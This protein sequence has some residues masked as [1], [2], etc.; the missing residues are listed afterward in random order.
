[1]ASR[2]L[3]LLLIPCSLLLACSGSGDD[4]N[5]CTGVSCAAIDACHL[6]GT[7]NPATG[8]CSNPVAA[9]GLACP[10]GACAAGVCVAA[11]LCA[12]V[13][14]APL[15]PCHPAGSCDS[16]T[17][18]CVSEPAADGSACAGGL[19]SSGVCVAVGGSCID[20]V[21]NAAESDVDCGGGLCTECVD[22]KSCGGNSDCTSGWCSSGTC[23]PHVTA[24]V[25]DPGPPRSVPGGVRIVLDGTRSRSPLG[26]IA[27][28]SWTQTSGPTVHLS[29]AATARP[30]FDAP[31][32]DA[33]E[34][35]T[36]ELTVGDGSS[37]ATASLPV[38]IYPADRPG[39]TTSL[40]LILDATYEG[41]L[42]RDTAMTYLV[43]S[44][45][46]DPRLPA[47]YQGTGGPSS[48]TTALRIV[49]Q[50]FP[51]LSPEAQEVVQPFL[52]PPTVPGSYQGPEGAQP[53]A[54]G[55]TGALQ[56]TAPGWVGVSSEHAVIWYEADFANG[57]TLATQLS[58]ELE[59]KIWSELEKLF[60]PAHMPV[61]DDAKF[62]LIRGGTHGKLNIYLVTP[63]RFSNPYTLG[64]QTPYD[65]P[66]APSWIQLLRTQPFSGKDPVGLAQILAHEMMHSC[67]D[68]YKQA[69]P[70]EGHR[71]IFEGTARWA[72]DYVYPE[73]DSEHSSTSWLLDVPNK[74]LDDDWSQ[75][76][77]GTYLFFQYVTRSLDDDDF[78]RR[79]FAFFEEEDALTAV[80][81]ALPLGEES[82]PF[83]WAGFIEAAWNRNPSENYWRTDRM[84][85]GAKPQT[86]IE[87]SM[88]SPDD[89]YPFA[90]FF[91]RHLSARYFVFKFP[92]PTARQIFFYDGFTYPLKLHE[93]DGGKVI[94][95]AADWEPDLDRLQHTHTRVLSNRLDS[96]ARV[97]PPSMPGAML[98]CQD[99]PAERV[100]ELVI[101]FGYSKPE[102]GSIAPEGLDSRLR[103]S[104]IGCYAWSGTVTAH[105]SPGWDGPAEEISATVSWERDPS[106]AMMGLPYFRVALVQGTWTMSGQRGNCTYAGSM[107]FTDS[108]LGGM[109][110]FF[111]QF[112]EGP[113]HRSY[114]AGGSALQ[115]ASYTRTCVDDDGAVTVT[116]GQT[117]VTWL[118]T[119][120]EANPE[121]LPQVAADG[122][123]ASGTADNGHMVYSWSFTST[124]PP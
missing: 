117:P 108:V 63:A 114:G 38:R 124:P 56:V 96:W 122:L 61:L 87:V 71:W 102:P 54:K 89:S 20:G 50:E 100:D 22:G 40:G 39:E 29:G 82:L 106:F 6:P 97:L 48:G 49:A 62:T 35:L 123:T 12:G 101:A 33:G 9:N 112:I 70:Y 64:T 4:A 11:D 67:Q 34:S 119:S 24:L 2:N 21:K 98:L 52:L 118:S 121:W 120:R 7:C 116:S 69:Q 68:S 103:A 104:N 41:R 74:S 53:L 26:A 51:R 18:A 27:S 77:Y 28:W 13:V 78:I 85:R 99:D 8:V 37:T 5:A 42:D 47:Q 73:I 57:L 72:E 105:T 10:G 58:R 43:F 88:S 86:T 110:A 19:C 111:P 23:A 95:P 45:Y 46:G 75:R 32:A 66:P 60:T 14:C 90:S 17:G 76:P 31:A 92:D 93:V 79:V 25:A 44:V 83:V 113:A 84:D 30:E 1:M 80:S 15:G 59:K 16:A 65:T 81:K 107:S 3:F 94:L 55:R 36:F 109:L 91:L 115:M